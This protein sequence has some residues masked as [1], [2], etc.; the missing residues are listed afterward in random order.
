MRKTNINT[1][2]FIGLSIAMIFAP[3]VKGAVRTWS[4]TLLEAL[5]FILI[6][7]WLLYKDLIDGGKLK[8]T[9]L[10][11]PISIFILLALLSG[12]FGIYKYASLL[13]MLRILMYVGAYY[14]VVNNFTYDL[15]IRFC[16]LIVIIGTTLSALGLGQYFLGLDHSWWKPSEFLAATYVNHN[17]FSGYIEMAFA[18]AFGFLLGIDKHHIP[19]SLK[20]KIIKLML[21]ISILI[22]FFAFVFAQS[23]GAWL[24]LTIA[25]F[26]YNIFLVKRKKFKKWTLGI[27]IFIVALGAIFLYSGDD[28][29]SERLKTIENK[30]AEASWGMRTKIWHGTVKMITDNPVLGTGIGTFSWGFPKYR[31]SAIGARAYY[32]HNDYLHIMAEVGLLVMS[33]IIWAIGV[34]IKKGFERDQ[35]DFRLMRNLR[36]AITVGLLSV[37]IHGLVDFNF[38][39][40]ANMLMFACLSGIVMRPTRPRVHSKK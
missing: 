36:L 34:I 19:D 2:I 35:N 14:L 7:I 32:A 26:V 25:F 27:F 39:I 1:V 22:M 4:V 40:P 37:V 21:W 33:V 23:R 29:V 5:V 17:H 13:E 28:S 30:G 20:L 10:D 6:F 3:V 9:K 15:R 8:P 31:T 18:I 11:A 24:S 16:W 12:I 38:H